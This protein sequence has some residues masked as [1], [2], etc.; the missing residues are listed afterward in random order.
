LELVAV[1]VAK[2]VGV[3]KV[4]VTNENEG[5]W[6]PQEELSELLEDEEAVNEEL[7]GIEGATPLL[8]VLVDEDMI[9][10][11]LY[12]LLDAG[13][14]GYPDLEDRGVTALMSLLVVEVSGT[15]TEDPQLGVD[16]ELKVAMVAP[17]VGTEAVSPPP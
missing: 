16:R 3:M 1:Y 2:V 14:V 9:S 11:G 17:Y 15:G 5:V 13:A 8:P 7:R 6:L 10:E 4:G 12:E